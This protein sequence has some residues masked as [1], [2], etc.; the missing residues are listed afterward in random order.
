MRS[1]VEPGYPRRT[2]PH[3][4]GELRSFVIGATVVIFATAAPAPAEEP[5][6]A[7]PPPGEVREQKETRPSPRPA[8]GAEVPKPSEEWRRELQ[9][10]ERQADDAAHKEGGRPS[11]WGWASGLGLTVL[12]VVLAAAIWMVLRFRKRWEGSAS[13][14]DIQVLSRRALDPRNSVWV[15]R[16]RGRDYLLGLGPTG[17]SLLTM[18]PL[19]G[20]QPPAAGVSTTKE[21]GDSKSKA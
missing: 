8:D 1:T 3:G 5:S 19:V 2:L 17:V 18:L 16:V 21:G 4:G 7:K 13:P 11:T 15:V 20:E 12:V 10:L 14:N 6:A 9:E